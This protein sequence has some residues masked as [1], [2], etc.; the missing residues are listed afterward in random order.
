M[1]EIL[2]SI[3]RYMYKYLIY[4]IH[5]WWT[6]DCIWLLSTLRYMYDLLIKV[7]RSWTSDILLLLLVHTFTGIRT[8]IY[9]YIYLL[10][11]LTLGYYYRTSTTKVMGHDTTYSLIQIWTTFYTFMR[12]YFL[13]TT[14]SNYYIHDYYSIYWYYIKYWL[15]SSTIYY[16]HYLL[17]TISYSYIYLLV[18]YKCIHGLLLTPTYIYYS[19]LSNTWMITYWYRNKDT[20]IIFYNINT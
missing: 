1:I 15:H 8:Y 13:Q 9:F 14:T 19:L 12:D 3:S 2:S 18:T 6:S 7:H 11:L 10:C 4:P 16:L 20:F 17:R 5:G